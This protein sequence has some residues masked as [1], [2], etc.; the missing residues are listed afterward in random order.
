[1]GEPQIEVRFLTAEEEY[2]GVGGLHFIDALSNER[3]VD[4]LVLTAFEI[5]ASEIE[6][7]VRSGVPNVFTG[8]ESPD[9]RIPFVRSDLARGVEKLIT[10]FINIGRRDVG[11]VL[12]EAAGRTSAAFLA[13]T[14]AA[15]SKRGLS[16]NIGPR[17]VYV[18]GDDARLSAA[19][20]QLI[21]S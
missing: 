21:Q 19:L 8:I 20:T 9:S 13:G 3:S 5:R 18:G 10:H 7:M 4:A 15:L 11:L 6:T 17:T 14:V 1:P 16:P 2:R 12:G